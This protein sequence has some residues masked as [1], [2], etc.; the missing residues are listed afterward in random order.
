VFGELNSSAPS[1]DH[2]GPSVNSK[3]P[4]TRSNEYAD[5][6]QDYAGV[7]HTLVLA[8]G[9]VI[10][11]VYVG[12]WFWGRPPNDQLCADLGDLHRRIKPDFD[13][14]TPEA[15]AEWEAS[16]QMMAAPA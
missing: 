5:T 14:T 16:R 13:P 8:P 6:H 4:A 7:P 2:T 11:K 10:D 1:G 15:R 12:Y 3:P 9:L